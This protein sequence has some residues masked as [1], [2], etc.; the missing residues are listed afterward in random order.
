MNNFLEFAVMSFMILI[1]CAF[2][3]AVGRL[4]M[5]VFGNPIP[6]LLL[7][8]PICFAGGWFISKTVRKIFEN[9]GGGC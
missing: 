7:G 2:G 6:A 1:S 5:L 3:V 8:I 4:L 9:F